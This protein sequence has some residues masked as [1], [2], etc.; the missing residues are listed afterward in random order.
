[1]ADKLRAEAGHQAAVCSADF[2]FETNR[3]YEFDASKLGEAHAQCLRLFLTFLRDER[4]LVIVSNTN[5]SAWEIAPYYQC[6]IALGYDAEIITIQCDPETAAARNLHGLDNRSVIG[7]SKKLRARWL[8][9][10]WKN[11]NVDA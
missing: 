9:S 10:N 4:P 6:A 3:G 11:T 2:F 5:L 7:Q 1:M 8:P